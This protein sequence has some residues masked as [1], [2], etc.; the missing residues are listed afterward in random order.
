ML[1]KDKYSIFKNI[2]SNAQVCHILDDETSYIKHV[3]S[4]RTIHKIF[5]GCRKLTSQDLQFRR[6][7]RWSC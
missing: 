1:K 7:K 3:S 2:L 4:R 5:P 6:V